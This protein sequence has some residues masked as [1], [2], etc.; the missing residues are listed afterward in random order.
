M[1]YLINT[2]MF[3]G[4]VT[5]F[6]FYFLAPDEVAKRVVDAI[7]QEEATVAIPWRINVIYLNRLLPVALKDRVSEWL[8]ADKAMDNFVGRDNMRMPGLTDLKQ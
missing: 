4:A 7:G 6:P 1:P 5:S 8:G 3:K 2:G